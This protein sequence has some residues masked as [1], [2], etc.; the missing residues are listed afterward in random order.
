M[1]Y[2]DNNKVSAS[3]IEALRS[4]VA[5][6]SAKKTEVVAEKAA[7]KEELTEESINE[8]ELISE[9]EFMELLEDEL[10][11]H[12]GYLL[13]EGFSPEEIETIIVEMLLDDEESETEESN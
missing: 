13:D 9:E 1:A 2:G 4:V 7:K 8:E 5:P 11:P 10:G 12:I 3:F 6:D